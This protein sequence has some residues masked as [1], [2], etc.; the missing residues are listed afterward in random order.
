MPEGEQADAAPE[1]TEEAREYLVVVA[2]Y[3]ELHYAMG[4]LGV[5]T[6]GGT[7]RIYSTNRDG[8]KPPVIESYPCPEAMSKR[9]STPPEV[10]EIVDWLRQI[11]EA[12]G[13]FEKLGCRVFRVTESE[14]P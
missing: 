7:A 10:K 3:C 1:V 9:R 6:D 14:T 4:A 5:S 13:T 2:D 11:T 8:R 12:K